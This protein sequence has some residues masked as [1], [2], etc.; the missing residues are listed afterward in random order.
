LHSAPAQH[1]CPVPPHAAHA[2]DEHTSPALHHSPPALFPG[3]HGWPV[4]PH[5]THT[6]A[7]HAENGAVQP[8]PPPQHGP[9][10]PPQA[11]LSHAPLEHLP[12]PPPQVAVFATHVFTVWSQHPPP[13]HHTPSQH[14]CPLPPQA[15]HLFVVGSHASPDVVQ[16][17]APSPCPPGAPVQHASP[18]PPQVPHA[19]LAQRPRFGIPPQVCPAARQVPSTQHRLALHVA[20]SQQ[21]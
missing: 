9:P 16:K 21:G 8:T 12:W 10:I 4:P 2:P 11:P 14:G 5:P 13:P 15:V 17:F 7:W 3:Q 18:S 1:G 20:L 19:A 6:L